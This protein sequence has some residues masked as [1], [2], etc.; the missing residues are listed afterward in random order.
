MALKAIGNAGRPS[1]ALNKL[2]E[3]SLN[4]KVPLNVSVAALEALR[5][6]PCS[7][8]RTSKLLAAY[9]ELSLDVE[10]SKIEKYSKTL[11]CNLTI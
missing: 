8:E 5:R 2:I 3:C 4:D 9:G 6:F 10:V 11:P 7:K 1:S